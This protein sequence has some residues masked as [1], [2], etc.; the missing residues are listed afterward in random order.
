MYNS[1]DVFDTLIGRL[2]YKG[3][4]V[5]E[6][7]E[8]NKKIENFK[9]N[10]ILSEKSSKT[11][12]E[13]YN[14][15]QNTYKDIDINE[16]KNYE[17]FLEKELSFPINKYLNSV[18]NNDLLVSDMYL[19][20][21]IVLDLINKH[22]KINNNIYV[23][24]SDKKDGTFWKKIKDKNI[25]KNHIGD[26]YISDYINPL[27]YDISATHINDVDLNNIEK[28]FIKLNKNYAYL[29]RAT[30]LSFDTINNNNLYLMKNV[31]CEFALPFLILICFKIKKIKNEL[32]I[33][34][35][36][37]LSRDGYWFHEMYK[38]LFPDDKINYIYFSR[39]LVKNNPAHLKNTINNILG[40]KL[41]F[42]LQGSG[43]T[44]NMLKIDAFYLL[45]FISKKSR[46]NR[47]IFDN[48]DKFGKIRNVIEDIFN[49]PHGSV[50]NFNNNIILKNMENNINVFLPYMQGIK[51]F[52]TYFNIL[53]KYTNLYN[54]DNLDNVLLNTTLNY[55][56]YENINTILHHVV[57]HEEK[58]IE[59]PLKFFSQ[60]EQ[61]KYYI[62]NIIKYK[63]N[64]TFLEIGGYDGITGSNTYFLEKNLNWNGIIVECNP[65]M[66][67]K[68]KE[69][70]NCI[71]CDKAIYKES[72]KT[73][74]FIIPKGREIKGGRE[75]L[76]GILNNL[77]PKHAHHFRDSYKIN[78]IL[79]IDTININELLESYKIYEIDYVSLDIEG[80]ELEVLK[81]WNFD[82]HKIKFLTV[83]HGNAIDYQNDINTYL[84]SKGFKLHRN[85][86]WDDEYW[87]C[88]F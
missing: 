64:G 35:I 67:K 8:K 40:K 23:S 19:S 7:I 54:I 75:Q 63:C 78:E 42:D 14:K 3:T 36:I 82:K 27:K 66:V 52:K 38:I 77:R 56:N 15:L 70:R 5:F 39:L 1:Y 26:N 60:I 46:H 13:I 31:F 21:E 73:I 88:Y 48:S 20:K 6:I 34:N 59:Y 41:I 80:Y 86:K 45:C 81:S 10:R 83:E 29:I 44:F 12:D 53:K 65:K 61:D 25:I 55:K 68:C 62:E 11:L 74:D 47:Y 30:R 79:K 28:E 18:K 57:N 87:W 2:C 58:Y 24:I 22:K 4:E 49:A 72:N 37:F 50:N 84:L 43:E 85:N 69:N 71:I 9:N 33:D 17:L 76:A 16:I 51:Y 32:N